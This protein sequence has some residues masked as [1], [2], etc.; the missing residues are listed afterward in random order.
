MAKNQNGK[1]VYLDGSEIDILMGSKPRPKAKVKIRP[2]TSEHEKFLREHAAWIEALNATTARGFQI[3]DRR[4][5]IKQTVI[6]FVSSLR[7]K[8]PDSEREIAEMLEYA[9][10]DVEAIVYSKK[11]R[12]R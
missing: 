2:P 1:V 5:A 9:R 12:G 6:K 7:K 10:V 4:T 3:Q 11:L 8:F